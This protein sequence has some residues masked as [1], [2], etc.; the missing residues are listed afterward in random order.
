MQKHK[1]IVFDPKELLKAL[2]DFKDMLLEAKRI[3]N[4][5]AKIKKKKRS[6]NSKKSKHSRARKTLSRV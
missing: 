4:E 5:K 6:K 1:E 3:K 2:T